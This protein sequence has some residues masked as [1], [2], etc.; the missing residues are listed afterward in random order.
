MRKKRPRAEPGEG[1]WLANRSYRRN[2][3]NE[4]RSVMRTISGKGV[5]SRH[6]HPWG[7]SLAAGN[8][9]SGAAAQPRVLVI[10]LQNEPIKARLG[11]CGPQPAV[12]LDF[13]VLAKMQKLFG[14]RIELAD[15]YEHGKYR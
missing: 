12:S 1:E 8:I 3:T 14:L 4:F 11:F 2:Q 15:A 9:R 7:I 6:P 5:A 13:G 10:V